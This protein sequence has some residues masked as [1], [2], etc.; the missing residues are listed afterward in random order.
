MHEIK[1]NR[2]KKTLKKWVPDAAKEASCIRFCFP[3]FVLDLIRRKSGDHPRISIGGCRWI[4]LVCE[5]PLILVISNRKQPQSPVTEVR[6]RWHIGTTAA[7]GSFCRL[8]YFNYRAFC[9][10]SP[11]YRTFSPLEFSQEACFHKN[12]NRTGGWSIRTSLF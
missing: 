11:N 3:P 8:W 2:R 5:W 12:K 7:S 1:K 6:G 9:F 4:M 10:R